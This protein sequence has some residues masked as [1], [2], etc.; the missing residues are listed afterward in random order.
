MGGSVGAVADASAA[1]AVERALGGASSVTALAAATATL[2]GEPA[3][4]TRRG[5]L[6]VFYIER[7]HKPRKT[8]ADE[9]EAAADAA[10]LDDED[11]LLADF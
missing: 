5:S 10:E 9:T 2:S 7:A 6:S 11:A 8:L 3:T 1:Q 4:P